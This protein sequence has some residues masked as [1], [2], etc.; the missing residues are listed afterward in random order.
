MCT[1]AEMTKNVELLLRPFVM[2]IS[3]FSASLFLVLWQTRQQIDPELKEK[4][5]VKSTMKIIKNDGLQSLLAG[6]GP[7]TWGYLFEGAI[8]FGIYEVLKPVVGRFLTWAAAVSSIQS[9]NSKTLGFFMCGTVSG[10]AAS[11]MLC[12]MEALRIRLVAEPDFAPGGWVEGGMK[13]LKYEGVRGLWKGMSA[14]MSKQVPYTVTK[15]VSFDLFTTMVYSAVKSSG[16]MLTAN[17]KFAIPLMSAMMASVLSCIS[18]Q[19]GDMLL[20]AVNAHGGDKRTRDFARDI[21]KEDGI[22]GFFR[23]MR[24]RFLHVGLI[25]TVQLLIYDFVKR[26]VGIAATGSV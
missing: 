17:M 4:G 22:G 3:G 2:L 24:A 14:M 13:M 9:L 12:P 21:L 1:N 26:L 23:G 6:L 10:I 11:V 25:V 19:P 5:M 16:Q 7:T 20:S 15:N 18:S 8:K